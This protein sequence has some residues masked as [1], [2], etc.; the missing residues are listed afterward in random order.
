MVR[1]PINVGVL[2]V[3]V[4]PEHAPVREGTVAADALNRYLAH[5]RIAGA[6]L[7]TEYL[8]IGEGKVL[9]KIKMDHP[10]LAVEEG[11]LALIFEYF[12]PDDLSMTNLP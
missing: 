8:P 2:G 11:E 10:G 5:E 7:K 3:V 9:F 1:R 6:P 12:L 4:L